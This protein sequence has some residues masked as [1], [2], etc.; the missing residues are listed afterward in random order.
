MSKPQKIFYKVFSKVNGQLMPAV[1][2]YDD[3]PITDLV[4]RKG[5]AM[6]AP[7]N[8]RFFL[9]EKYE[10]ASRFRRTLDEDQYPRVIL[11]VQVIGGYAKDC[12]G[13][14]WIHAGG[15][16]T[17]KAEYWSN[18]EYLTQS[19]KMPMAKACVEAAKR[20]RMHNTAYKSVFA[21]KI[22]ILPE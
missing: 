10:D 3:I 22:K 5:E 9:F 11:P 16:S 12:L 8:T 13:L 17:H 4:Y 14:R 1:P 2:G 6:V 15:V 20:M 19:K 21:R 7:D 18:I